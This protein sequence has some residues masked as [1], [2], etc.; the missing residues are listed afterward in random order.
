M[1]G[2]DVYGKDGLFR[3]RE[4]GNRKGRGEQELWKRTEEESQR[5]GKEEKK[6]AEDE[7]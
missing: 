4:R 7:G 6:K 3:G 5:R 2:E 1:I